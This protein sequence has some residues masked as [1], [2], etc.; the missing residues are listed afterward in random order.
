MKFKAQI[1]SIDVVL[2]IALFLAILIF[3]MSLVSDAFIPEGNSNLNEEAEDI[4]KKVLNRNSSRLVES[5]VVNETL[6]KDL[7]D[8]EYPSLKKELRVVS[9]FCIYFEDDQGNIMNINDAGNPYTKYGIGSEK[10]N[11]SGI[12]CGSSLRVP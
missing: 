8:E 10:I 1:I 2:A 11:L 9:D 3:F 5:S 4:M 7:A 6:L 12:P